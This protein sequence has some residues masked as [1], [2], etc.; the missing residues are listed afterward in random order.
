M[1]ACKDAKH[2]VH[3]H[4]TSR[5]DLDPDSD[6]VAILRGEHSMD[7]TATIVGERKSAV[8]KTERFRLGSN[9]PATRRLRYRLDY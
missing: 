9:I 1:K 7:M 8:V 3:N 4:G 6:P 5:R 2:R